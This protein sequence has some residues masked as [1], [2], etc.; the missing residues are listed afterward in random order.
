MAEGLDSLID[1][2]EIICYPMG[3]FYSSIV[4]NLL[5]GGVGTAV[6]ANPCPKVFVPNT[7][8]DA[9][10]S[11]MSMS[12]AVGTLVRSLLP[13]PAVPGIEGCISPKR[14]RPFGAA[15]APSVLKSLNQE[16]ERMASQS[17]KVK[18]K[19]GLVEVIGHL[20][21]LVT[22]LREGRLC[23]RKNDEAITLKPE[24]PVTLE[25]EAQAKL[26]KDGLREKLVIELK[27]KKGEVAPRE[28]ENFTI[29]HLEPEPE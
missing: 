26:E 13:R 7:V 8:P 12:D 28:S 10:Q 29:T 22:S 4:A 16:V 6:A 27:W 17:L 20:E 2:A 9:E 3:S 14:K 15:S 5:P 21:Q 24:D 25:L 18:S 11:G 19:A 1:V 23:I